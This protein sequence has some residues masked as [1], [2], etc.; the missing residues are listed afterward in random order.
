MTRIAGSSCFGVAVASLARHRI[1]APVD[2]MTSQIITSVWCPPEGTRRIFDRGFQLDA[3]TVTCVAEPGLMA[4]AANRLILLSCQ[5]VIFSKK[6][7]MT[8]AAVTDIFVAF[9]VAFHT[10]LMTR[11][12][13]FP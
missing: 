2:P 4:H 13:D 12:I 10:D 1:D 11:V 5:A 6:R 3:R 9:F 7:C 8:V